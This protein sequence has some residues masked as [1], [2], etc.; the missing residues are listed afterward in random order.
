MK[1]LYASWGSD[2][3]FRFLWQAAIQDAIFAFKNRM[4][5]GKNNIVNGID[6]SGAHPLDT[7]AVKCD[8][9]EWFF[10]REAYGYLIPSHGRMWGKRTFEIENEYCQWDHI[11]RPPKQ[12]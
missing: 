1:K 11:K 10:A 3:A 6:W 9:G 8:D 2:K 4:G 7:H 5:N 12:N